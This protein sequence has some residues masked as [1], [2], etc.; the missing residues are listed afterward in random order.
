MKRVRPIQ[1]SPSILTADFG[2]L[3]AEIKAAEAGGADMIHLDVMDGAFVPNI[4]FGPL[5]VRTVRRMTDLPLDVHL[6]VEDPD[7]YLDVFVDAGA[8]LLTV[9]VEATRHINRT[10]QHITALGCGAGVALNPGTAV[11]SVREVIPFVDMVL[12]MSVN[13]GFGSQRFIETSTSK[14]RRMRQLLDQLNP[15]C[16]LQVDGGVDARNIDDVVRSGADVI[17]VG[18]AVF[19]DRGT[20][21]DN[22]AKLR[23]AL[24]GAQ[25]S[26]V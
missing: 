1:I 2:N 26:T 22:I 5:L 20:V 19:N 7:R 17:V 4:T 15:V 24:A 11:E 14:L 18:S 13:P 3:A 6:M 10:L 21:A 25:W 16:A 8:N 9:H 23:D 12:V